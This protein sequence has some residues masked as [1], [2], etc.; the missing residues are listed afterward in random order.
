M[1]SMF[2]HIGTLILL[3]LAFGLSPGALHAAPK[4]VMLNVTVP[5]G[6][7]K[8]ARL[9]NLPQH[10]RV[11]VD[12][13]SSAPLLV[14]FIPAAA[15]PAEAPSEP[16]ALFAGTVDPTLSF[17][18]RVPAAGHYYL[19]FDNRRGAAVST[20][21]VVVKAEPAP[22]DP[23]AAAD[24]LLADFERG[25]QALFTFDPLDIEAGRCGATRA[26]RDPPG[27]GLCLEYVALLDTAFADP[28]MAQNALAV[29]IFRE[30]A[31]SLE[32]QWR[33]PS[34]TPSETA[35]EELAVV[36][37]VML[38]QQERAAALSAHVRRHPEKA[39]ELARQVQG[40][41]RPLT[42]Q[43][44][45]RLEARLRDASL[46]HRWQQRLVPH[47]QTALL[48]KLVAAPRP[49]T[50][51]ARVKRELDRRRTAERRL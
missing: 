39:R 41:H 22:A 45:R 8:T 46:A 28:K 6:Q 24:T 19:L 17:A 25:L 4:T 35:D 10:A 20:A 36:L 11:A 50:D 1:S 5:P 48:E 23:L 18:V 7:V 16:A 42:P 21:K 34:Q 26:F 2:K 43:Q 37:M 9:K 33:D 31:R 44:A 27:I 13:A 29:S 38:E 30:V 32:A 47:M 49:W 51:L 12:I 14:A 3:L 40:A 15:L